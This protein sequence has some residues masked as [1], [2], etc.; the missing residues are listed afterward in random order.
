MVEGAL[1]P[2]LSVAWS[3]KIQAL[4]S[5]VAT[6][7]L[8]VAECAFWTWHMQDYY[9]GSTRSIQVDLVIQVRLCGYAFFKVSITLLS[10][11]LAL[12]R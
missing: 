7:P 3:L 4:G 8:T 11:A 5:A 12:R 1:I 10:D 2:W 6:T 9:Y